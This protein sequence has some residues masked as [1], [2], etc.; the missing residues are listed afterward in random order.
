ML[1][2]GMFR[3][4]TRDVVST[5]PTPRPERTLQTIVVARLKLE[6]HDERVR[7]LTYTELLA[8]E[9]SLRNER[10]LSIYL[11]GAA[12]N[13]AARRAWRTDLNR[14]IR[15]L[16]RWLDGSSHAEREQFERCVTLLD[17]TLA[18][19]ANGLPSAGWAG[20]ITD[21]IVDDAERLPVP[22]PTMAV[23]STGMCV[24]PYIRAL[25]VTRPVVVAVVDSRLSRVYRWHAGALTLLAQ[26]H[27][28][29]TIDRPSHMG[30]VPRVGFHAGV[31]GE[32]TH[33][34][35]QRAHAAG[36]AR[37]LRETELA[38]AKEASLDGGII[39]GGAPRVAMQLHKMLIASV[40]HRVL[41]LHSLQADASESAI[42]TAAASGAAALRN[43]EDLRRVSEI[44]AANGL[45][46][47]A[48]VGPA[49]TRDALERRLV[50]ELY[51]TSR[52]LEDHPIDAEQV[53][54][55]ALDQDATV[56]HVSSEAAVR[57][58]E[59]GGV[60]ARLRYRAPAESD[61]ECRVDA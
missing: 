51:V 2:H 16:R 12:D 59:R 7:M 5:R 49:A 50:R 43:K 32:T 13:P 20:F 57:L 48:A 10:V 30:D 3:H 45:Q 9:R 4:R 26:F 24:A 52:Y 61:V 22:M 36:T 41:Q 34:A 38:I 46:D 58:D 44:I 17:K 31:R 14:S 18:P 60:G 40:S 11:R 27:A 19:Y 28:H 15:D 53:V 37:M 8:L 56:E 21:G 1:R 29:S 25:K 54:R 33:D 42:A 6:R 47:A 55:L 39:V 23:W 35:V